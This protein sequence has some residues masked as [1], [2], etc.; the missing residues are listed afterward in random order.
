MWLKPPDHAHVNHDNASTDKAGKNIYPSTTAEEVEHHLPCDPLGIEGHSLG[1]HTMVSS[2]SHN[3]LMLKTTNGLALDASNLDRQ[4]LQA[5]Q[6]PLGFGQFIL[7]NS[8]FL[9]RL[10]V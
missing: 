5:P 8:G 6:T 9:H 7:A 1:D 10:S 3:S 2:H 4:V